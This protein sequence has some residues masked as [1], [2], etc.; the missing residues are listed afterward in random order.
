MKSI[1]V[2][3]ACVCLFMTVVFILGVF[4]SFGQSGFVSGNIFSCKNGFSMQQYINAGNIKNTVQAELLS[5]E[6]LHDMDDFNI[7][8]MS[9]KNLQN[10]EVT[11]W[12]VMLIA[13][14]AAFL[15]FYM[16]AEKCR[17]FYEKREL[18]YFHIVYFIHQ[19]DGKK[20]DLFCGMEK[21]A[22]QEV[23]GWKLEQNIKYCL[24]MRKKRYSII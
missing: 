6:P 10:T 18:L 17:V 16:F 15:L 2:S 3:R 9:R 8:F 11:V 14:F 19:T 23:A 5:P 20:K 1:R 4:S 22:K 7:T 24:L 13:M 21:A 12:G